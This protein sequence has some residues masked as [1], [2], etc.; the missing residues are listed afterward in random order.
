LGTKCNILYVKAGSKP[1]IEAIG[2]SAAVWLYLAERGEDLSR[3][4]IANLTVWDTATGECV[5]LGPGVVLEGCRTVR[6]DQR[7][8]N[9]SME[10]RAAGSVYRCPLYAF[11]PRT[12]LLESQ[13][14]A[15]EP[16]AT[17]SSPRS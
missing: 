6:L 9:Y 15:A 16:A 7:S 3:V 10:F 5:I 12:E 11:Q 17:L 14:S 4:T 8:S 13:V 2:V 1:V